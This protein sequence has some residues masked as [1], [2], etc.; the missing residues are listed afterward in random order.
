M[1]LDTKISFIMPSFN[2]SEEYLKQAVA[3]V[4]SQDYNNL[5]LIIIDDGSTDECWNIAKK[6]SAL[7]PRIKLYR[8]ERN[9]G[10]V[11]SLN[12]ALSI[13]S[14]DFIFRMDADDV[15]EPYRARK[16]LEYM[17]EHPDVDIVGSQF[18]Y[19]SESRGLNKRPTLPESDSEIKARL[20]WTTPFAHPT[21]CFRRSSVIKYDIQY[22]TNEKAEDYNLWTVCAIKGCKFGNIHQPLLK[23]R[24]HKGQITNVISDSIKESSASI[25]R[26]LLD[27][28]GISLSDAQME[29]FNAFGDGEDTDE[30][31]LKDVGALLET[32]IPS[33]PE[34]Y[35]NN[36][37]VWKML[38]GRYYHECL[39]ASFNGN[40]KAAMIYQQSMVSNKL[41]YKASRTLLLKGVSMVR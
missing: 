14:G 33:V 20:L 40:K 2:T 3:S 37:S 38:G 35:A 21:V 41:G 5:E 31:V 8:N 10:I 39:R 26:K 16:T 24:I 19:L 36:A 6:C 25:R 27:F 12:R 30:V 29:T 23:Y 13:A 11:Y 34:T 15:C 7:D 28:L 4:I 32:I 17:H 1:D 22:E 18:R 9:S